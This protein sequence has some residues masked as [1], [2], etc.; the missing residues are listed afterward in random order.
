MRSHAATAKYL[1]SRGANPAVWNIKGITPLHQAARHGH[2][3]LVKYL[4]SLG[5]PVDGALKNAPFTPL[6]VAAQCGQ[7]SAV[8]V[9][10]QHH[11]DVNHAT[12]TDDT[13][14]FCS[15][16]AGSLECTKLLIK[17]GADLNL[18]CPLAMA[19]HMQSVE[20]IKC[21]LEA[22]ADPNVCNIYGQLPIETAIMG[23]NRNIIE[24]LFPLT[25]PIPEVD[26]WSMQGILQYVNSDGFFEKV[27][28]A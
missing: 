23:K 21:L 13:P 15:V 28:A 11:A 12:I 3:K 9:L 4:L 22:G 1:I 17:A 20:I 18:K 25:S 27:G 10:L 19:V 6:M 7:A 24:M 8:K 2:I 16:R 14:L 26:D 5:V